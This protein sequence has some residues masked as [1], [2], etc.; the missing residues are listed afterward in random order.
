LRA[1]IDTLKNKLE[2]ENDK[3]AQENQQLNARI[4]SLS[5]KLL[6]DSEAYHE[7]VNGFRKTINDLE[8]ELKSKQN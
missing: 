4:N 6:R 5:N 2:V 8:G 1:E 7:R 3:N